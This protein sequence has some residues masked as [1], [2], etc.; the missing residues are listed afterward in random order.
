MLDGTTLPPK[1]G[2][3]GLILSANTFAW[4]GCDGLIDAICVRIRPLDYIGLFA[5]I[6]EGKDLGTGFDTCFTTNAF[7]RVDYYF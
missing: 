3:N 2:A 5:I 4:A 1:S 6:I 7:I